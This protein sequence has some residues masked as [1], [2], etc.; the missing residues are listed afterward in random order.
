MFQEWCITEG[1]RRQCLKRGAACCWKWKL[2]TLSAL[3]TSHFFENYPVAPTVRRVNFRVL[4]EQIQMYYWNSCRENNL[5]WA[6]AWL[7]SKAFITSQPTPHVEL[8]ASTGQVQV[9]RY[10]TACRK[11][12]CTC[13][14]T[15]QGMLKSTVR[16][17]DTL[18]HLFK[19]SLARF[20]HSCVYYIA[21]GLSKRRKKCP[22][23]SR[24]LFCAR[25]AMPAPTLTPLISLLFYACSSR[26]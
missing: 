20:A 22:S 1:Y 23:N 6:L 11:E 10:L 8:T 7:F 15:F 5:L 17:L 21:A 12:L 26:G 9:S 19:H 4:V 13:Y 3:W 14:T 16:I 2:W 25:S 18:Y 24:L